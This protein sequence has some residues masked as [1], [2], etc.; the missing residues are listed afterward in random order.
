MR[1]DPHVLTRLAILFSLMLAFGCAPSTLVPTQTFG[2]GAATPTL[3][4]SPT[5]APAVAPSPTPIPEPP[6]GSIQHHPS[7]NN[8]RSLAFDGRGGLWAATMSGVVHWDLE[9]GEPRLYTVADGVGS[10]IVHHLAVDAH[11]V[12]WVATSGGVSR[13]DGQVWH[14]YTMRDGLA[15]DIVTSVAPDRDGVWVGTQAG[16]S[17]LVEGTWQNL[18]PADGLAGDLVWRVGVGADDDVW[19]STHSGG[20]GRY[21][22]T[23]DKWTMYAAESFP[24]VNAR[25]LAID[26][27]GMPW[28]H[29]GY[30]NVYR[31]NGT[32][33]ELAYEVGGGRWV[34]DIAFDDH[35]TPYIA[36]CV[37]YRAV[38]TGVAYRENDSWHEWT[39]DDG[40]PDN[41]VQAVAVSD[42]GV[43]AVGTS[44]G[45]S[46][47]SAAPPEGT[48]GDWRHL[49]YGP[50]LD[51]VREVEVT[52]DG[53]VWMAFGSD[54]FPSPSGGV[55]RF[56]QG[57]WQYYDQDLTVD[58]NIRALAAAPDGT[59][60]IG[61]GCGFAQ[62]AGTGWR[63]T[64]DCERLH[65]NVRGIIPAPD[66][67]I[68]LHTEFNVYHLAADDLATF[69]NM[70]PTDMSLAADGTLWVAHSPL[71]QERKLSSFDGQEWHDEDTDF[72]LQTAFA[73]TASGQDLWV[74]GA[75][76]VARLDE[77]GW[78]HYG[79]AD[80]L[81]TDAASQVYASPNGEVWVI[82]PAGLARYLETTARF[83]SHP[84][85]VQTV[86][87][88]AFGQD[89]SLWVGTSSGLLHY[90]P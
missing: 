36:T 68:W 31:F 33:W 73:L 32:A 40:L 87:D 39:V 13:F 78:R 89:G 7:Y 61:G 45:V 59:L 63:V 72:P 64:A 22:T 20:V 83:E 49:R 62:H 48:G 30:D 2:A 38:G 81:P 25:V 47:R 57:A 77:N 88:M 3:G 69:E 90:R 82:T 67:S 52:E 10:A 5:A 85:P 26:R 19:F 70:L 65:G 34:C 44:Y 11:G 4:P 79:P 58:P 15:S 35:N 28:V 54:G 84:L 76:G 17:R 80:G 60:W 9:T 66:G 12:L 18:G 16:A 55:T 14:T 71:N 75:G 21:S 29:I 1:L 43:V 50:L 51:H 24:L 56:Y 74:V 6:R 53:A 8:I 42:D 37:G 27:D 23:D 41:S 86:Y 46:L